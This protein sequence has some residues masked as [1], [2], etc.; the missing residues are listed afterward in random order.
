MQFCVIGVCAL[1]SLEQWCVLMLCEQAIECLGIRG[2]IDICFKAGLMQL[3][4]HVSVVSSSKCYV[5][6]GLA[7]EATLNVSAVFSLKSFRRQN[8]FTGAVIADATAAIDA[9]I[10]QASIACKFFWHAAGVIA[11]SRQKQ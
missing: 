6:I 4:G 2:C 5:C 1:R 11:A 3:C 8:R 9:G 7:L 10:M